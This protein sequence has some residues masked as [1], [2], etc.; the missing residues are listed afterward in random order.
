[1]TSTSDDPQPWQAPSE[2]ATPSKSPS[3]FGRHWKGPL[4]GVIALLIGVGVGVSGSNVSKKNDQIRAQ[5]SQ[6]RDLTDKNDALQKHVDDRAA[7]TAA[8]QAHAAA[9][10]ADE[11]VASDKAAA[12]AQAKAGAAAKAK[13][14]AAAKAKADADAAAAAAAAAAAKKNTIDGDGV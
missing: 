2:I 10:K 9:V 1:M 14:A 7:Q 3:W 8:D 12:D 6:I 13:A 4:I 11:R 5:K